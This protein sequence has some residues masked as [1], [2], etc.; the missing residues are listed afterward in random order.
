MVNL[1]GQVAVVTGANSGIGRETARQFAAEGAKVVAVDICTDVI[2]K[3]AAEITAAG[4]SYAYQQCDVCD[5]DNVEKVIHFAAET[6]GRLDIVSNN[7][8]IST[9]LPISRLPNELYDKVLNVNLRGAFYLC[10]CAA[11]VMK[12]QTPMG[13]VIVNTASVTGIYGSAMGC[14][15]PASKG[16]VIALTKSLAME[17]S[18]FQ[19]RVNAVAPGIINTNMVGDMNDASKDAALQKGIPMGHIGEPVDVAKAILFLASRDAGYITG[20]CL[21][22][23]GGY[24]S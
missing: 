3:D 11:A 7:A 21:N 2:E 19:I 15:Y 6:F 17:L 20:A 10:K 23:D 4:G 24:K 8:G 9:N 12:R 5:F 14:A 1:K 22:V 18:R 13:G 16:G